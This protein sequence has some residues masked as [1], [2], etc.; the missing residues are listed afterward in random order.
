MATRPPATIVPTPQPQPSSTLLSFPQPARAPH[1]GPTSVPSAAP[2]PLSGPT[3]V[4]QP[5]SGPTGVPQH[6]SGP[7]T[8][9]ASPPSG[10]VTLP[11]PP[12]PPS[13][14]VPQYSSQPITSPYGSGPTHG[15]VAQPIGTGVSGPTTGSPLDAV[16]SQLPHAEVAKP[17][18]A[19]FDLDELPG[20]EF[21]KFLKLSLRRAFRLRIEPS[22]VLAHERTAL[23][24]ASPPILDH[25]L[26]AFL[27]WRRSV[28]FVVACA[29]IPLTIIGIIGSLRVT[30]WKAIFFVKFTPAAA[31]A[32]FLWICWAQLKQWANWRKQRR[33][34]FYGWL[35]FMLTPFVVF[36]YPLNTFFD[37]IRGA[38][39]SQEKRLMLMALGVDGIYRQAV[40]PFVFSMIAML[41]LAP[42]AISLMPGLIRSSMVIKLLFPGVSA[43]GW[44]IVMASPLY[45]LLAYVIL[46]I[47]YQFTGSG[48]FIAGVLGVVI[49]QAVLARAGFQLA[50]PMS[51]AEAL[52]QIK[53]VRRYYVTVMITS[54]VLIVVALGSLVMK[55]NLQWT[56]VVTAVLKFESNVLILTMIGADL[57]VTNLDKARKYTHGR[58]DVEDATEHKIAAFVSFEAPP[59]PPPGPAQ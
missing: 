41:Q 57:V 18:G 30:D 4:P 56:D 25:N 32:I 20:S 36:V 15:A 33:K 3:G 17:D 52:V 40:M 11:M 22:E 43:P 55:L 23:E 5:A 50:R 26:Q 31:E 34:L 54:A 6:L 2:Q 59:P 27:A 7:A 49:G 42:K 21:V 13:G 38:V 35:L 16:A 24:Q 48:W 1:S 46:I 58:D 53:K 44:L 8:Q 29:L 47:P 19:S 45:A 12:P 51:E 10:A 37:E 28:L 14:P 9:P 39:S